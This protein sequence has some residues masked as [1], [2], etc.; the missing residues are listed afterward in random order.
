MEKN[1]KVSV[2]FLLSGIYDAMLGLAFLLFA[3]KLFNIFAVA[4]PNHWGYIQFPA[5][6]LI[7]FGVMFLAIARKPAENRNMIPYGIMLKLAYC[8]VV[9][10]Y[11]F[12]RGIPGMWKPFAII[13][14]LFVIGFYWS[15]AALKNHTELCQK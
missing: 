15:M 8:L 1:T 6:M 3:P 9:F 2:I 4:P 5:L 7:I 14:T 13:D 11:W 12:S 10:I